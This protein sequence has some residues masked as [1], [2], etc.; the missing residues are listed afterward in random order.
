MLG[1][2]GGILF[3][4]EQ[5]LR[6]QGQETQNIVDG[7][8]YSQDEE[9]VYFKGVIA[10]KK[11][12]RFTEL[13]IHSQEGSFL[14]IRTDQEGTPKITTNDVILTSDDV[15]WR[16][17]SEMDYTSHGQIQIFDVEKI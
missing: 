12:L 10:P 4:M 3:P 6:L 13:G 16:V 8:A 9:I 17:T 2:V 5:T 11:T 14:Y 15:R 7:Y 1:D